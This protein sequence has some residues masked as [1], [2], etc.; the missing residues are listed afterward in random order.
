MPKFPVL[1]LLTAATTAQASS[2]IAEVFCEERDVMTRKLQQS[3]GA[4]RQG[5]GTRG[6]DAMVEI[7]TVPSSGEWTMVQSYANGRACIVAMGENWETFLPT[8]D[9]A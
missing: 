3:H 5:L 1:C 7:W 9:P 8:S 2:P 4:V 6:P